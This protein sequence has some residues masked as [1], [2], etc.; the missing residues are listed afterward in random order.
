MHGE[1]KESIPLLIN[2]IYCLMPLNYRGDISAYWFY[3]LHAA[4]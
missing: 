1:L 4:H 3:I 2:C